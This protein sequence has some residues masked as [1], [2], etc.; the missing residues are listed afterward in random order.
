MPATDLARVPPDWPHRSL[1]RTVAVGSLDW[2]VQVGGKGPMVMLLHGTGASAHS[3]ADVM[4]RLMEHATVVVPDLP[5]HGFTLGATLA[6]LTLPQVAMALRALLDVL[7]LG[8]PVMLVGHSAGAALA[9]RWALDAPARPR[10]IVG[11]N[12]S[13]VAPPAA[14]TRLLA[15]VL[16][17]IATSAPVAGL[18]AAFTRRTLTVDRLLASTGSQVPE[19]QRARYATLFRQPAHIR[20]AM[21]LMAAADL[22]V[23]QRDGGQL[24]ALCTF[25][26]GT[27]D[28]WVPERLLGPVLARSFPRA[29]VQRWDGGHL[30][31]EQEPQR[32]A[33]LLLQELVRLA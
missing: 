14:Y 20:G 25:V 22:P 6:S 33:H 8:A 21:G 29:A 15:P 18:L 24:D 26:L 4:P 27:R 10:R 30:L 12:P 9:L 16:V 2:H 3:W 31:H 7:Q 28:A 13:L 32:A 5:G 23:L 19:A 11:F 17:P 1:S